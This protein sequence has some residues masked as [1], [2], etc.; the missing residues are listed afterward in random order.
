MTANTWPKTILGRPM[1][2]PLGGFDVLDGFSPL[3]PILTYF[4]DLDAANLPSYKN[5]AASLDS[6]CPTI[7]VWGGVGVV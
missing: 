5:I 2:L 3:A 4:E 7:L 1:N 6:S